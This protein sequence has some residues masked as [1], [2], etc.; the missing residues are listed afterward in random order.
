[1]KQ[2]KLCKHPDLFDCLYCKFSSLGVKTE[3]LKEVAYGYNKE[4]P[5][6]YGGEGCSSCAGINEAY[7]IKN[8]LW[9]QVRKRG[10]SYLCI[11]CVESRLGRGLELRDFTDAPINFGTMGFDCRTYVEQKKRT[12]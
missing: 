5:H 8:K 10:E 3:N 12:A 2:T 1:M 9:K 6:N 11:S 7:M 4:N